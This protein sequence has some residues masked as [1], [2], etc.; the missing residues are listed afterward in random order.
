MRYLFAWMFSLM[1]LFSS[2]QKK[3][4]TL[5]GEMLSAVAGFKGTI[6][7]YLED[8]KSG[9]SIAH[10]ADTLFPTASIIKV[11]I[12]VGVMDKIESGELKYHQQLTYRD[13]LLYEGED[14]LGSFK[15]GEKIDLSKVIMLMLTTSDNTA[16]LWLQSLA[17]NGTRINELLGNLGLEHTRVNS[18][19]P[20]REENR[21]QFGWGQTTPTEMSALFKL[22]RSGKAISPAAS[23]KMVRLLGRN[24][25]DEVA[26]SSIPAG[27]FVASKNGAVN[28]SRSEALMVNGK[29]PYI[30]CIFTKNNVDQ[31]WQQ[32]NEAW[33][34]IRKLSMLAWQALGQ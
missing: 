21:S 14:I 6:G 11:P 34:L 4:R 22:I 12:L 23:E 7:Y 32:E 8:L 28:A 31:S 10:L 24:Y 15:D 5:E 16:S 17:G 3:F 9:K 13:S 26:L 27:I 19:T 20:G 18:R 1:F 30:L 33:V 2:G 29:R 25:W